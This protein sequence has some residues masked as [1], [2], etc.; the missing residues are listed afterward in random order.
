MITKTILAVSFAAILGIS[1]AVASFAPLAI[2]A[3]GANK[4]TFNADNLVLNTEG[5][6]DDGAVIA[7]ASLKT[8]TPKDLVVMFSEECSLYTEVRLK[9]GSSGSVSE[10]QVRAAQSIWLD[11]DGQTVPIGANDDGKVTMCDRTYNIS[12]NILDQIQKLC[13]A[14]GAIDGTTTCDESY[15][16]SF[17]ST[18]DAHGWNWVVLNLGAGEHTVSVHSEFV[19]EEGVIGD[20]TASVAVGKRSLIILPQNLSNDAAY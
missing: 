10:S 13:S 7:S 3:N 1:L 2:A 6:A 5:L 4:T 20:G 12:T 9:S 16:N 14:V 8:S 18:K 15:F 19:D 11:V 17:I